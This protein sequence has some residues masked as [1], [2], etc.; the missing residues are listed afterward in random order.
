MGTPR[1]SDQEFTSAWVSLPKREGV[2]GEKTKHKHKLVNQRTRRRWNSASVIS[3]QQQKTRRELTGS[4]G[5]TCPVLPVG[6]SEVG[7]GKERGSGKRSS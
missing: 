4:I 1:R 3:G 7:G 6:V 2:G 5:Q